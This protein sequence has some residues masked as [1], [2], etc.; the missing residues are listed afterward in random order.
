MDWESNPVRSVCEPA[1]RAN[2]C[3]IN[4]IRER[5]DGRI[6]IVMALYEGDTLKKKIER[7][8]IK[9]EEAIDIAAPH[10]L[11]KVHEHSLVH[12]DIK[13]ANVIVS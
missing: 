6:F 9:V 5:D 7:G 1:S 4:D 2:G 10:G 12:R 13:P 11:T 3:I 8:P